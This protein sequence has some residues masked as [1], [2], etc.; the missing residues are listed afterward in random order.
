MC[1]PH[2]ATISSA[3]WA[4]STPYARGVASNRIVL[5]D[6]AFQ[7]LF[8]SRAISNIGNGMAPIALAFGIL[9]LPG[10]TPA[11]L[12][13]VLAAQAIMGVLL[14]PLGGVVA[15]RLGRARV[16]SV[17]DITLSA[18]IL[19]EAAL[20]L[21][22]TATIPL[23][24]AIALVSG[25]LNALWWPAYPGLVPDVVPEEHLQ[26]ANAL[27]SVASNGGL[28]IGAT[29]GGALVALVGSG[30]AI[31]VDG[32]SFLIAGLLV[33][34]IRHLSNA[35]DSGESVIDDLV[36]G[37]R[38]FIS[39][40]WVVVI[41]AVFSVIVM[42]WRG[43]EE[44]MGPVLARE[45]Y[46][47]PA[48]WAVVTGAQAAG[49]LIGALIATRIRIRRPLV[50]GMLVMFTL[51]LWLLLLAIQAPLVVVAAG[52]LL[53]GISLEL[54]AVLWFTAMQLNIPREALSRVSSYDAF[55]SMMF[56]PIGLA[57]AGPFI[58][59]FGTAEAFLISAMVTAT[60]IAVSFCFPAV[61]GLRS[62]NTAVIIG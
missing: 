29:V 34:S 10:A 8:I 19:F 38:V 31:A 40:R 17:T 18:V 15:D 49:L 9:D 23:L 37:W 24:V 27:M 58:I 11:S 6:R 51:P 2:G 46:G 50:F 41:V 61:R 55:G 5:R 20:F 14:L 12:S 57:V 48:G 26:P 60:A 21:T 1:S 33:F 44:V 30:W 32:L 28:I 53:F 3:R 4:E 25:A 42:V 56:G 39:Y 35:V 52:S 36:H 59:A 7:R 62:R 16:I 54:F 45:A 47:G 43:A 13:L 22:G